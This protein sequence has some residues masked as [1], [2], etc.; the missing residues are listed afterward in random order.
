M[1]SANKAGPKEF[2][3]ISFRKNSS[4]KFLKEADVDW[5]IYLRILRTRTHGSFF[6]EFNKSNIR[7]RKNQTSRTHNKLKLRRLIK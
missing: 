6:K 1:I 4:A 5:N 3:H 7:L 2:A